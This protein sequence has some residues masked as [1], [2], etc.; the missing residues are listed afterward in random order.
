MKENM[1]DVTKLLVTHD[2]NSIANMADRVMLIDNGAITKVGRPLEVIEHYLKILHNSSFEKGENASAE[3]SKIENLPKL[4]DSDG[5][6]E[7]NDE[8]IGGAKD[9]K[10]ISVYTLVNNNLGSVVKP[11]DKLTIKFKLSSQKTIYDLICGYIIKDKYGNSIFGQN[12]LGANIKPNII[13]SGNSYCISF[14]F[15]WPEIIEGDYFLTLGIGEGTDEM[16]HIIQCWA[17]NVIHF[18]AI[19]LKPMHGIINHSI[20]NFKVK[21]LLMED[22]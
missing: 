5:W 13:S 10:I 14:C 15:D 17:H 6:V 21:E 8:S 11:G 2:M 18:N 3:N 4:N 1:K 20:N 16:V 12:T 19:S 7:V 22:K 9:A